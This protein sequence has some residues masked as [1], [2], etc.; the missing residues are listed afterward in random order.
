MTAATPPSF[1]FLVRALAL[2]I[3]L[4]ALA[5][6]SDSGP[7]KGDP[8]VPIKSE[9][10][11][12]NQDGERVS[13]EDYAGKYQLVYFGFTFCP[14][15]CPATLQIMSDALDQLPE[16]TRSKIQPILI[17]V[18]PERDDVTAMKTYTSFFHPSFVGLTGTPRE[19]KQAAGNFRIY[20]SKQQREED[21]DY[22]MD[23]TSLIYLM[24]GEGHYIDH[25]DHSIDAERLAE[26]LKQ[27]K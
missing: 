20:Y 23:H 1:L 25:F 19:I 12:L 15:I 13:E 16:E 6:C 26:S 27:L 18:D 2:G 4:S 3:V 7:T 21:S 17:T 24:D 9:F 22:T 8:S 5:A 11:L 10:S 14:D